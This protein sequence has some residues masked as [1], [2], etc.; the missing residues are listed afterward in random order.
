MGDTQVKYTLTLQ[1][2]LTQKLDAAD[3]S[4]KRF[5]ST[6]GGLQN[7]LNRVGAAVGI[8]L[9]LQAVKNF[10]KEVIDAGSQVENA[11]IGLTTLLKDSQGAKE[12][13]ANT[14]EDAMKTPFA[15][16]GLLAANKALIAAG[17]S[18]Q[19]ARATVLDLSNAI[20][21]TGGGDVELE[22]MVV[23]LQQIK[24]TGKATAMDIKQF[25][26]AGINIYE[27]LGR[28]YGKHADQMKGVEVTYDQLR[29]ALRKAHEE[30]GL[31]ANGLENMA[32]A[33]SVGISNLG[34]ALFQLKV[35]IFN[36]VKPA[37]TD[38]VATGMDM[39]KWLGQA[40]SWTLRN[41]EMLFGLAKGIIFGV[42]AFKAY[43]IAIQ[44]S[45]FWQKIQYAS[46]NLLG[47]GFLKA[48]AATKFFAG[49]LSMI[50]NA[51]KA[52]PIGLV[53]TAI[54]ALATAYFAFSGSAKDAT[55]ENDKLNVSL[56][57][58]ISGAM[59][60]REQW[61]DV[62]EGQLA[63]MKVGG[64]ERMA[65][66]KKEVDAETKGLL[67]Q[68]NTLNAAKNAK[69]YDKRSGLSVK[70]LTG[71][72]AL[73]N[74]RDYQEAIAELRVLDDFRQSGFK[75]RTKNSPD[76][77]SNLPPPA[78]KSTKDTNKVTGNKSTNIT[79]HINNLVKEFTIKTV[80]FNESPDKAKELIAQALISAVN[81]SQ[82]V[83]GI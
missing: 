64:K 23:N 10:A 5:D 55:R 13:I 67:D 66:F 50:G 35:K 18:A 2:L 61:I 53:V 74:E 56:S 75:K 31:Y 59:R 58:T 72:A 44:A 38:L 71:D 4:A 28:A 83:A 17:S 40:W 76:D 54:T 63:G 19:A 12:V 68:L 3:S 8:G 30:G 51:I 32:N 15:F 27:V 73:Q 45:I 29:Y 26:Y 20:A 60:R 47:D 25:A 11:Q 80:T 37:V 65:Y 79:I 77:M 9:G 49:G 46:I 43:K 1:D 62:V 6:M 52:N 41:R 14:M 36:D 81:D 24:T 69:V 22:R 39:I 34:D 78:P 42:V 21:A 7:S 82:R 70:S 16:E 57:E 33:T 48:G